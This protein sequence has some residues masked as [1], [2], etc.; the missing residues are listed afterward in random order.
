MWCCQQEGLVGNT[1]IPWDYHLFLQPDEHVL[2]LR[3]ASGQGETQWT[4]W[5]SAI[6]LS[7]S[8]SL[9]F[10]ISHFLSHTHASAHIHLPMDAMSQTWKE[11]HLHFSSPV[12]P[13]SHA[14]S[15]DSEC[16]RVCVILPVCLLVCDYDGVQ[17]TAAVNILLTSMSCLHIFTCL[18]FYHFFCAGFARAC[19]CIYICFGTC[20]ISSRK[21]VL[22]PNIFTLLD[23]E[24][25][26]AEKHRRD[27]VIREYSSWEQRGR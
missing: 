21:A 4:Q 3:C 22:K 24:L 10:T 7:L 12:F 27:F 23:M 14:D 13:N 19:V 6:S 2:S 8:K 26:D 1:T 17:Y 5:I 15:R 11:E 18:S 20:F 25:T 9:S 16:V